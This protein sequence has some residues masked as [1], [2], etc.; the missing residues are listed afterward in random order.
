MYVCVWQGLSC[1]L[2]DLPCALRDLFFA[3]MGT[4]WWVTVVDFKPLDHQ[5][6]PRVYLT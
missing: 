6:R 2:W 5:G 1:S 4:L 3:G